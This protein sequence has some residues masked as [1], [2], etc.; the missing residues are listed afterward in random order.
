MATHTTLGFMAAPTV[1]NDVIAVGDGVAMFDVEEADLSGDGLL[2]N[3]FNIKGINLLTVV[4]TI[5]NYTSWSLDVL[6]SLDNGATYFTIK[7]AL[8]TSTGPVTSATY[9]LPAMGI[10]KLALKG[11]SSAG[12]DTAVVY[13]A[14][15]TV[16]S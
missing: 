3:P 7:A 9:A 12:V 8:L 15:G 11:T 6:I 16:L 13:A 14:V 5:A 1:I 10:A 4:A 2:S